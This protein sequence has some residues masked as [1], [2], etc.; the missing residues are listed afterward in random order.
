MTPPQG[1]Y[2][3]FVH[4][5]DPADERIVARTMDAIRWSLPT[6][7]GRWGEV[8]SE[9]V[10][11]DLTGMSQGLIGWLVGLYEPGTVTRW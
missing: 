9:T 4:L 11:L 5:F 7:G 10:T 1:D 8:V 3:I 6:S 2:K